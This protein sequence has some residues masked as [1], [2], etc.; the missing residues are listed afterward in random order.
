MQMTRRTGVPSRPAARVALIALLAIALLLAMAAG[1]RHRI[2]HAWPDTARDAVPAHSCQAYDAATLAERLP[3]ATL[4]F[5]PAPAL[6]RPQPLVA[7]L[8]RGHSAAIARLPRGPPVF[9]LP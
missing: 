9:I 4:A 7:Q 3:A 8:P 5:A 1:L 6:A 2:L